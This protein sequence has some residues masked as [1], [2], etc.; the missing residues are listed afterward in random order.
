MNVSGAEHICEQEELVH[1]L[2][3]VHIGDI[4]TVKDLLSLQE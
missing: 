1:L 3:K 4:L 2:S